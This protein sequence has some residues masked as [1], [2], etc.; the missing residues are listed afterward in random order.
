M[1]DKRS[2]PAHRAVFE[3]TMS[4]IQRAL[5]LRFRGKS[6]AELECLAAQMTRLRQ[7]NNTSSS[8]RPIFDSTP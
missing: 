7:P 4:E 8:D 5:E 6:R 2:N 1:T 3:S